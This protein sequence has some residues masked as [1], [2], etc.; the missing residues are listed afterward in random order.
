[1]KRHDV[2]WSRAL[3]AVLLSCSLAGC[4]AGQTGGSTA[5][6][7]AVSAETQGTE[8]Q[9]A[10]AQSTEAPAAETTAGG[11]LFTPGVYTG[12]GQGFGGAV[13]VEVT[14]DEN[15]ILSIEIANHSETAG[16]ADPALERI[17]ANIVEA[18]SIA[19]DTISGCTLASQGIID[20]VT[21][22]LSQ[23]TDNLEALRTPAADTAQAQGETEE[24]TADV[25]I[26]G[27][28]AAGTDVQRAAAMTENEINTVEHF[29][30]MEPRNDLMA[31]WQETLSEEFEDYKAGGEDYLFDSPSLHKLQTYVEGD[32]VGNPE[33]IDTYGDHALESFQWVS[34][35]GATWNPTI[36]AAIGAT[37]RRSNC[38]TQDLGAKGSAFV[39]P[40]K[41]RIDELGGTILLEHTATELLMEDGR[42]TGVKG[43]KADGGEFILHAEDAVMM[44]TG[45]FA[46]NVEMREKYNTHWPTL[47]ETVPTTNTACSTGDGIEMALKAGANLV[48][49]EWI[50]LVTM[51]ECTLTA[52]IENTIAVNELGER[53]MKEDGRRDEIC[54]AVLNQPG[55]DY[56]VI[57][58][59]HTIVDLLDGIAYDGRV[60]EDME[61]GV[62][63]VLADTVEELEEALGMPKGNLQASIDQFHN[64]M[65][66]GNDPFGRTV[67]EYRLD[68]G[69]YAAV[70]QL[71]KVHHTMGGIEINTSCQVLDENG[72]VIPGFY[73][74]GEVTGGIHGSNRLGGN[75][76]TDAITFGRIAGQ[77][78]GAIQ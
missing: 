42:V 23:A 72:N 43:T 32:Y 52:S 39:V 66:N 15:S 74:A 65:D 31:S 21:D 45:G 24:D 16:V 67:F 11:P 53:F 5:A 64:S 47:D 60:I 54:E 77:S 59:G 36:T 19:V 2:K 75:A 70:L 37:Y 41:N 55:G 62:N 18:Q 78:M 12:E 10:E 58:D 7:T 9:A 57:Y 51:G 20:A 69:P 61:D 8:T 25:V 17:P 35:L 3:A 73:A 68:K 44:A 48:G 30:S 63:L 26:I 13:T 22:A 14:V 34:D 1:M 49:M 71:P 33:L 4:G 29:I 56:Y 50:Q 38:P 76:I 27:T 46:A 28:G 40:Q 6:T